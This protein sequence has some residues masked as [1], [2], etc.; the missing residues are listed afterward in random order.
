MT[1]A[2][3][4]PPPVGSLHRTEPWVEGSGRRGLHSTCRAAS[5]QGGGNFLTLMKHS[6]EAPFL[7]SGC[8]PGQKEE[9][10]KRLPDYPTYPH[11]ST[12][13]SYQSGQNRGMT[14]ACHCAW[15]RGD[16]VSDLTQT[17]CVYHPTETSG[18][19]LVDVTYCP[20]GASFLVSLRF[21]HLPHINPTWGKANVLA[22]RSPKPPLCLNI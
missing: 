22:F 12:K 21:K 2:E 9:F 20:L 13:H 4:G 15:R 7:G 16:A 17:Q 6:Y 5:A 3:Q 11:R 8:L 10:W 19:G 1:T 14:Q 18:K